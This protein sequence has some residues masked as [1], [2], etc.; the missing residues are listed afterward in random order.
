MSDG[1]SMF[2]SEEQLSGSVPPPSERQPFATAD[3]PQE[4]GDTPPW[5]VT[6]YLK[7]IAGLNLAA[8]LVAGLWL[9]L[10]IGLP[11][12]RIGNPDWMMIGLGVGLLAEGAIGC[13]LLMAFASIVENLTVIR[14]HLDALHTDL[15]S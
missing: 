2:A 1:L 13:A 4:H 5:T 3:V 8:G 14:R 12:H 6:D 15:D 10:I 11:A 7:L 9:I